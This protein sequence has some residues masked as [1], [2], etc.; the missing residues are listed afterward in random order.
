MRSL[1]SVPLLLCL[2]PACAS[3]ST[4][5][6]GGFITQSTPDGTGPALNNPSLN[7][8]IDLQPYTLTLVTPTDITGPGFYTLTGSS[9]IFSVPSAPATET[10]FGATSLSVAADGSFADF[11]LFAC[12]T[13]GDCGT[14]N[15]LS[16]SFQVPLGA[17]AGLD[18]AATGQDQPHPF[19]LLEDDGVTDLH[20]SISTYSN[21]A[22][23]V[24]PEPSTGSLALLSLLVGTIFF[25]VRNH[26]LPSLRRSA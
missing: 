21:T 20:G 2:I 3:A 23:V 1:V 26:R 18:V 10:L 17:V 5:S 7:N 15:S 19:E 11:S 9:L 25:S 4:V 14:G 24:T 6:I 8:I 12:V 16:A 13:S 22:Q